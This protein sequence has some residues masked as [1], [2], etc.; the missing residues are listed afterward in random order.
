[1]ILVTGGT[2]LVGSH[3]LFQISQK[4]VAVRAIYRS[5]DK[6]QQVRRIFSYY[7][8]EANSLFDRIEW[9][10]A[11]LND[12]S[13]LESAFKNIRKVYH[14]AAF[15]SFD[16]NDFKRLVRVNETGTGNIVNLCISN[17]IEKL[18]YVSSIAALGKDPN[19]SEVTERT[20]WTGANVNPYALTKYLAEM[21]AWRGS[22]E[23]VPTVIVNPGVILGPGFW[24]S[25]S[26]RLFKAAA[27][28]S[29]YYPP[30]G[31]GFIGVEDLVRM[32]IQLMESEVVSERFI[33]VSDNLTYKE[34]L[35]K[36]AMA[37]QKPAPRKRLSLSLLEI[38][39][40]LDWAWHLIS[41]RKR[42]L[43]RLQVSSLRSRSIYNRDKIFDF[44]NF[45]YTDMNEFL[46]AYCQRFME[47]YPS[48]YS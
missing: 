33:A 23:G 16:P 17:N 8:K 2:G 35:T 31:T 45:E 12:I 18:C 28:G 36:L 39:W 22:Q 20:E 9:I 37:L 46:P 30:G 38:L 40:R 24:E 48:I 13:S 14:C 11:D 19:S 32:M 15:I 5:E 44:I 21:E 29:R 47:A 27:R 26:G 25:G 43:S 1:M 41:R 34:V 7:S 4:D 6:L 42:K 10:K 3:L